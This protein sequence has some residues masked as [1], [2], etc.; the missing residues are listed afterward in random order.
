MSFTISP[1]PSKLQEFLV[2]MD[3]VNKTSLESFQ[4]NQL[5]AV[6]WQWEISLLQAVDT[7]F[8]SQSLIA[9]QALSCFFMLKVR[10]AVSNPWSLWGENVDCLNSL[11]LCGP[12]AYDSPAYYVRMYDLNSPSLSHSFCP[13]N[14]FYW[15]RMTC[16]DSFFKLFLKMLWFCRIRLHS[17]WCFQILTLALN[18]TSLW[19]DHQWQWNCSS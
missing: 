3:V 10:G 7:I 8:P 6:G 16:S 17:T 15:Y 14:F 9:G 12:F 19:H 1:C 18:F 11:S 13:S 4:V 5:S 2:R